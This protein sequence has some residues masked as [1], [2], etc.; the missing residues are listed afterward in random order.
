MRDELRRDYC[1]L[2][3]IG[4]AAPMKS[5]SNLGSFCHLATLV[6]ELMQ[7]YDRPEHPLLLVPLS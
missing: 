1:N 7:F 4:F 3:P 6:C 5:L 2:P